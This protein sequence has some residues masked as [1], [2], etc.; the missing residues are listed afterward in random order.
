MTLPQNVKDAVVYVDGG[1]DDCDNGEWRTIRAELHRLSDELDDYKNASLHSADDLAAKDAE[2]ERLQNALAKHVDQ[3]CGLQY[4]L[5][6]ANALL[7]FVS[8]YINPRHYPEAIKRIDAHLQGA[9]DE[10]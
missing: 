9:G 7:R 3:V 10:A 8:R 5:A 2:I 4:R 6:A 1:F